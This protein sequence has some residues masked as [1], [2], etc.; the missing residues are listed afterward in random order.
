VKGLRL[1]I[2][3]ALGSLIFAGFNDLV[4]KAYGERRGPVGLLI[5]TVGAIWTLFFLIVALVKQTLELDLWTLFIG[6]AAG[7]V[8]V[9]ANILFIEAMKRTGAGVGSTVYR[10]NLVFVAIMGL[11]LLNETFSAL[12]M[13][14]LALG[15]L[16]VCLFYA[17]SGQNG[18]AAAR[19]FLAVLVLA[20]FL[21]ACMGVLYKVASLHHTG[22]EVFLL[23]NG[24]C[25]LLAG[26]AYYL[27]K[28]RGSSMTMRHI[29]FSLLSGLLVCGIVLFMMLAVQRGEASVVV[30]VSQFSFL[31]TFPC[32]MLFLHERIDFRRACGLSLAVLCILCFSFART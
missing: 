11:L 10:L 16:S 7:L 14:G 18:S 29:P 4:F 32:A 2:I 17:G 9:A 20:S 22:N 6:S 19:T 12:K 15:V 28:E 27:V 25:W 13:I 24:I 31:V 26:V 8:S 21:R 3:Y 1:P 30:C 5:A 23:M